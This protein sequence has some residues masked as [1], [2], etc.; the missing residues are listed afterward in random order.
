MFLNKNIKGKIIYPEREISIDEL[1]ENF[2]ENFNY[3][4]NIF[5]SEKSPT[6][7]PGSDCKFCGISKRDCSERWG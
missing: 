4:I 6:K 7:N 1:P 3:F 2:E 5:A